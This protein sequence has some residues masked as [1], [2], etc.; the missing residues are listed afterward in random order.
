M[1]AFNIFDILPPPAKTPSWYT[2]NNDWI[3]TSTQINETTF[4]INLGGGGI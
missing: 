1:L 2:K 4:R 3:L